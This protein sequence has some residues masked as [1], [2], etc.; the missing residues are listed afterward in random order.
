MSLIR[1]ID[2]SIKSRLQKE[3]PKSIIFFKINTRFE[4]VWHSAQQQLKL[5]AFGY[6]ALKTSLDPLPS[7]TTAASDLVFISLFFSHNYTRLTRKK[8]G[9][10]ATFFFKWMDGMKFFF[11]Q[12]LPFTYF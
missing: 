3:K 5:F 2:I 1:F 10:S 12:Q 4:P 9:N 8:S 11:V 7:S 6:D